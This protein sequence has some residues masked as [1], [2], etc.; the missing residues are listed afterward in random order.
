[1]PPVF[2]ALL[3][4]AVAAALTLALGVR[5]RPLSPWAAASL[6]G[7]LAAGLGALVRLPRWWWALLAAFPAAALVALRLDL[8][9]W[10]YGLAA[11]L[12]AVTY[13]SV[14][15]TR[16]PLFLSR[17]AVWATVADLLPP[18]SPDRRLRFVDLGSAFGGLPRFVARRRPDV[19]AL[20]VEA[21]PLPAL[22]AAMRQRLFPVGGTVLRRG[23]L[24]ATPLGDVDLAFAFL[25]PVPMPE[26]WRKVEREMRSGALFVSCEFPVPDVAPTRIV[27]DGHRPLYVY[28]VP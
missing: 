2:R 22:A 7:V 26:L 23:D 12:L 28:R 5:L 6:A 1:M 9:A 13:G 27:D 14:H 20:G 19:D 16:V 3:C 21:A 11:G 15:R 17:R 25:S 8:P 4:L 18:P 24:W 10:S